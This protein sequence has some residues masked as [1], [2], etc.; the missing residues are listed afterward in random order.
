MPPARQ[1]QAVLPARERTR[2][3][4][5]AASGLRRHRA[6]PGS[7]WRQ[8]E[9]L[10]RPAHRWRGATGAATFF[11]MV[12]QGSSCSSAAPCRAW[13][14]R[15][16]CLRTFGQLA[17]L[18][19]DVG[20][21]LLFLA[22]LGKGIHAA[23]GHLAV[24]QA[25]RWGAAAP[26]RGVK[27]FAAREPELHAIELLANAAS[28][29]FKAIS[30]RIGQA[31]CPRSSAAKARPAHS[32][33]STHQRALASPPSPWSP[34]PPAGPMAPRRRTAAALAA[35]PGGALLF[36]FLEIL[37]PIQLRIAGHQGQVSQ[38]LDRATVSSLAGA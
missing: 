13:P 11:V 17:N 37:D 38:L 18:V 32:G 4:G 35:D 34:S 29:E 19:I 28:D 6:G 27:I 33:G 5:A 9:H 14:Y 25:R 16:P 30:L 31:A 22:G 7:R 21:V 1:R 15:R 36:G 23:R 3:Q 8:P 10:Q 24:L 12:L 20:N 2:R 26:C